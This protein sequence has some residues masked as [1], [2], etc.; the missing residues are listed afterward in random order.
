MTTATQGN[1]RAYQYRP[2]DDKLGNAPYVHGPLQPMQ[3]PIDR[4]GFFDAFRPWR[5]GRK[6]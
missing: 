1:S 6:D 2:S 3:P 5:L 4:Y